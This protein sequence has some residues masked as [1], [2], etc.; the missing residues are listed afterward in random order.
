MST[1]APVILG[2]LTAILWD[3][4]VSADAKVRS[5]K[6]LLSPWLPSHRFETRP[7]PDSAEN[8]DSSTPDT[9]DE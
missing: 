1:D 4:N 7:K 2:Q 6:K 9:A 8:S 5:L 3:D